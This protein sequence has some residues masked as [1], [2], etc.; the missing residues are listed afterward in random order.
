MHLT[1]VLQVLGAARGMLYLHDSKP[2]IIHRDLKSPKLLVD[3]AGRV[4]VSFAAWPM[5]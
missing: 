4:K 3:E 1:L 2:P 5:I